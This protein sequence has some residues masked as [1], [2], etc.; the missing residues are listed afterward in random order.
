[1][2]VIGP[3]PT[4]PIFD[5]RQEEFKVE[6]STLSNKYDSLENLRTKIVSRKNDRPGGKTVDF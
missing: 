3:I 6:Q 5:D 2:V 1:M 4:H